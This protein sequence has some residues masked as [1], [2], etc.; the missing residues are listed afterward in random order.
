[1]E[2][3]IVGDDC[4]T[5]LCDLLQISMGDNFAV[6]IA[7]REE[8]ERDAFKMANGNGLGGRAGVL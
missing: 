1:M 3:K 7:K 6:Q 5:G 4:T 2:L 8:A